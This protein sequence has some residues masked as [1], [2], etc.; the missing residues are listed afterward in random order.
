MP[1][2]AW[3]FRESLYQPHPAI[4]AGNAAM[5]YPEANVLVPLGARAHR[6]HTPASK[7]VVVSVR[8]AAAEPGVAVDAGRAAG[9]ASEG[10]NG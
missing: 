5:Y 3:L 1:H 7:L 10:A 6:S 4:R 8:R 2:A 9:H